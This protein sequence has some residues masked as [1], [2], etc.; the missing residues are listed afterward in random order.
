MI[1]L[2]LISWL[3]P[4]AIQKQTVQKTGADET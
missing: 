2:F 3:G 4:G 1:F